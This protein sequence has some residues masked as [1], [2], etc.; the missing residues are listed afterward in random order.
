MAF[1]ERD[2]NLDKVQFLTVDRWVI[3][4]RSD[5][6]WSTGEGNGKPLQYYCLENSMNNGNYLAIK[7]E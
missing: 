4:E 7:K 3:V 5:R 1:K 2:F 6:L